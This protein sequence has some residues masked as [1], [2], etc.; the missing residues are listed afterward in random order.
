MRD[1]HFEESVVI[2]DNAVQSQPLRIAL[3]TETFPPEVNGVA[4]TIARL[5]SQLRSHGHTVQIIRPRQSRADGESPAGAV[6][7]MGFPIPNYP[8]LRFG[9]PAQRLLVKQWSRHRPDIVHV[10][11]EGPLGYSAVK[12]AKRLRI[13]VT[14]DYRTNFDAYSKHY[15]FGWLRRPIKGYLIRFHNLCDATFVPSADQLDTLAQHGYQRLRLL[16]RGID[17]E[18]FNPARRDLK[19]RQTWGADA[20]RPVVIFVGRLAPEK[21]LATLIKTI[22]AMLEA[23]PNLL[24]VIV[25]DGP[26]A[27]TLR[28]AIPEA[29]MPGFQSGE[30]LAAHYAS[31]DMMLFPSLTETF[32]NVTVE[33][34]ACGVPVVAYNYAA[35]A[36]LVAH[37]RSGLLAEPGDEDAFVAAALEWIG[38]P[39]TRPQW[40]EHCV[41]AV[42]HLTWDGIATQIETVWR[43][44]IAEKLDVPS[45]DTPSLA[46]E[47]T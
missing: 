44:L 46:T 26:K 34:L 39:N 3:V 6:L 20:E 27:S 40:S 11:T 16:G 1:S 29:V 14:S 37:Q 12:A 22:R 43:S 19:L 2:E 8:G 36:K 17:S 5:A 47:R 33:A 13:P 45:R 28:Q 10:A 38:H 35:A 41:Q 9:A 30:A 15:G 31:A 7:T 4:L 21:N 25:G 42:R 24:P 23:Q 32:G 18:I